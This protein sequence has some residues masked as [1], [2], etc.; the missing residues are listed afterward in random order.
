M[1]WDQAGLWSSSSQSS[2][3]SMTESSSQGQVHLLLLLFCIYFKCYLMTSFSSTGEKT[4]SCESVAHWWEVQHDC[5]FPTL[6]ASAWPLLACLF[7]CLFLSALMESSLPQAVSLFLSSILFFPAYFV[8][9]LS[10]WGRGVREWLR[11]TIRVKPP[12]DAR[13]Q[14]IVSHSLHAVRWSIWVWIWI[15]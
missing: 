11:W 10:F 2:C 5:S 15:W 4:S 3:W 6:F 14:R 1:G 8:L 12:K 9:S 7:V 13:S